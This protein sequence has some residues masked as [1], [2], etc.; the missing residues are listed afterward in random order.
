MLLRSEIV[1]VLAGGR[2]ERMAADVVSF[3]QRCFLRMHKDPEILAEIRDLRR[4]IPGPLT[5]E[6]YLLYSIG[7][8]LA[9]VPGD[10]AEVGTY[11]GGSAY[12]M[13]LAK[14]SKRMHVFD[15]FRGL[16][17]GSRSHGD[18]FRP[19]MYNCCL[20]EVANNLSRFD[21]LQFH[22]GVFPCT[23]RGVCELE[24]TAY[25]FVNID[26]D[27]YQGTIDG[28]EFFYPRLPTGGIIVTHDYW[29][30]GVRKAFDEFLADKREIAIDLPT[31]QAMIVKLPPQA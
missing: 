15:T 7:R 21:N 25:S 27:L 10:F 14:G 2:L 24:E 23:A 28:L 1:T 19:G 12:M 5:N 13:C 3:L 20:S 31:T 4:R 17:Q 18:T 11:R 26:V 22:K 8:S 9:D 16:P 29:M 6:A 30:E